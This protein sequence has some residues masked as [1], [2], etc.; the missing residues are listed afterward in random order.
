MARKSNGNNADSRFVTEISEITGIID[1]RYIVTRGGY[2]GGVRV[3]GIDIFNFKQTDREIAIR[4]FGDA[5]SIVEIP[6]KYVFI[7]C[8]PDYSSQIS[9]LAKHE[10]KQDNNFRRHILERQRAWLEYYQKG[11]EMRCVFVLFFSPD[12][13]IIESCIKKYTACLERGKLEASECTEE[14]FITLYNALLTGGTD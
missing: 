10:L 3:S 1:R 11:E 2:I 4:A 8:K 14:D 7:G 9:N 13:E 12:T 6:T 5:I